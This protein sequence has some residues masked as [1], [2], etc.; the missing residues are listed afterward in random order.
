M[1]EV[2]SADSSRCASRVPLGRRPLS[3]VARRTTQQDARPL[4]HR[5]AGN[6]PTR[7]RPRQ[8][9]HERRNDTKLSLARDGRRG[10]EAAIRAQHILHWPS[11]ASKDPANSVT[12]GPAGSR[13]ILRI[14]DKRPARR[15]SPPSHGRQIVFNALCPD[16]ITQWD[17]VC[18]ALCMVSCTHLDGLCKGTP[19]WC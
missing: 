9:P 6:A 4:R 10:R 12:P 13:K 14:R 2:G 11:P 7:A 19:K 16:N 8:R 18:S 3:S 15:T 1:S 17:H 5:E